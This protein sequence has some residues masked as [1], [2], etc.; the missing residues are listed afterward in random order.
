M[1]ILAAMEERIDELLV[2]ND[3]CT[4]DVQPPIAIKLQATG[5][6]SQV[7]GHRSQVTGHIPI[8]AQT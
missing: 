1:D 6:R 5:H 7:T 8:L 2:G 3:Q 4:S